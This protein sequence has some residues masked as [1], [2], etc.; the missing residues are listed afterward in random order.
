MK[1]TGRSRINTQ[2]AIYRDGEERGEDHERASSEGRT[3][4]PLLFLSLSTSL[5][6]FLAPCAS[7][8]P[9]SHCRR[10]SWGACGVWGRGCPWSPRCR[11]RRT[12]IRDCW[13]TRRARLQPRSPRVLPAQALPSQITHRSAGC[14]SSLSRDLRGSLRERKEERGSPLS[15]SFARLRSLSSVLE[16]TIFSILSQL[17]K[18][19][20]RET[21]ECHFHARRSPNHV[22]F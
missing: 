16:I 8:Y 12:R 22:D 17:T 19:P 15:S 21:H 6:L 11:R 1:R 4:P 3:M 7:G 20:P 9:R 5:F 10:H 2:G 18:N 14:L 13:N